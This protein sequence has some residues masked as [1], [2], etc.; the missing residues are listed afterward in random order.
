MEANFWKK[1]SVEYEAI[2]LDLNKKL[3]QL[4]E[5]NSAQDSESNVG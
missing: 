2:M 5:S 3:N 4:R 1:K